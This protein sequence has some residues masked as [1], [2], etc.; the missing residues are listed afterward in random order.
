MLGKQMEISRPGDLWGASGFWTPEDLK[1]GFQ[2]SLPEDHRRYLP[3][4]E[5]FDLSD[6]TG[7]RT[8]SRMPSTWT[9]SPATGGTAKRGKRKRDYAHEVV[10]IAWPTS[11]PCR[12][13]DGAARPGSTHLEQHVAFCIILISGRVNP[14]GR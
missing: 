10:V 12:S 13:R 11:T 1:N 14:P 9:K 8:A 2:V 4:P 6:F 3:L 5:E 7:K